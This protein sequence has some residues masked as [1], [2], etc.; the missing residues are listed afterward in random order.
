MPVSSKTNENWT[1]YNKLTADELDIFN[2]N[3]RLVKYCLK[4]MPPALKNRRFRFEDAEQEGYIALAL[5]VQKFDHNR[6]IKFSTY[7]CQTIKTRML[8]FL[9]RYAK[10]Y[11]VPYAINAGQLP[12]LPK[13]VCK[14]T[15]APWDIGFHL[16]PMIILWENFEDIGALMKENEIA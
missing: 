7:A 3:I 15:L 11:V 14:D 6:N 8:R 10:T 16:D 1:K 9:T 4:L 5:A 2:K 12:D 13:E